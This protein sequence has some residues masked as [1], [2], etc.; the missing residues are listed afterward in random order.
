MLPY[1]VAA[2]GPHPPPCTSSMP[3]PVENRSSLPAEAFDALRVRLASHT[4]IKRALDWFLSFAPPVPPSDC[5]AQ[6]EF[7][8]DIPFRHPSGCWVVYECT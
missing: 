7:S 6:D 8:H 4:S 1:S 2:K 3:F 5:L